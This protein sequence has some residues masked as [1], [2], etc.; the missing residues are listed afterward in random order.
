VN[1]RYSDLFK[2]E[3]RN[4][5]DTGAVPRRLYLPRSAFSFAPSRVENIAPSNRNINR[6]V[7]AL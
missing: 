4:N 6:S 2:I 5:W 3:L 7:F 1:I